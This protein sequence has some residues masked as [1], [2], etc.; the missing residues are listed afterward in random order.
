VIPSELWEKA[1]HTMS[2]TYV[3]S[4]NL[5]FV[6]HCFEPFEHLNQTKYLSDFKEFVFESSMVDFCDISGSGMVESPTHKAKRREFNDIY[7]LLSDKH[8]KCGGDVPLLY[9][10][11]WAQTGCTSTPMELFDRL[12]A[13]RHNHNGQNYTLSEEIIL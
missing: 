1:Q 9:G 10:I 5:D 2:K 13:N 7:M 6:K 8:L 3:R 11:T 12:V 4:Q